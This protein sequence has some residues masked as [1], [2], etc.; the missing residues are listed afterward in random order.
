M[1]VECLIER[2]GVTEVVLDKMRYLFIPVPD[3]NRKRGEPSTSFCEVSPGKHLDHLLKSK[4]QFRPYV[5]GQAS[6]TK[7][8]IDISGFAIAVHKEGK[9]E[10]YRIEDKLSTPKK[11]AG[12]D[13][14]WTPDVKGLTPFTTEWEAYQWLKGEAEFRKL[15]IEAEK[16]DIEALR[17]KLES[18]GGRPDKR[19][20]IDKLNEEIGKTEKK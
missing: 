3:P 1:L 17:S 15:E 8:A 16:S 14:A 7:P 10:G 2:E 19:W 6:T 18:L 20:G 4:G 13:G 9:I 11:Y 12:N 5:Q